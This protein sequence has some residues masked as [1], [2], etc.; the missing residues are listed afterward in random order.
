MEEEP[1]KSEVEEEVEGEFVEQDGEE[2]EGEEVEHK[3]VVEMDG[4]DLHQVDWSTPKG[5]LSYDW[6]ISRL[7]IL[8]R[9]N[10]VGMAEDDDEAL[11]L[12]RY[13]IYDLKHVPKEDE[14]APKGFYHGYE[15]E[16]YK[17]WERMAKSEYEALKK[18]INPI[19]LNLKADNHEMMYAL[20]W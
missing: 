5:M 4:Y 6:I 19:K 2:E 7:I 20:L 3:E 16:V 10:R 1:N 9:F 15:I 17:L 14:A 13:L 8:H 11:K 12:A 18:P